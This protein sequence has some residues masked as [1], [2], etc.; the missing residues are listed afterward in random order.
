MRAELRRTWFVIRMRLQGS[1]AAAPWV[2]ATPLALV[3]AEFLDED[4]TAL[5]ADLEP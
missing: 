1:A 4:G 2:E 5:A 3:L